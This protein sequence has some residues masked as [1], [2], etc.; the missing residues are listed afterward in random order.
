MS[1]RGTLTGRKATSEI[2]QKIGRK[3]EACD[4]GF[5]S[6]SKTGCCR[7]EKVF[8]SDAAKIVVERSELRKFARV[9]NGQQRR[10]SGS[11]QRGARKNG[12]REG[13]KED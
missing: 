6:S 3:K 8:F 12:Q 5:L 9:E 7:I 11:R 13:T 10:P 4:Q 2:N 1:R